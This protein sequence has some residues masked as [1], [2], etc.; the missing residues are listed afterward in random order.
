MGHE[1]VTVKHCR[2]SAKHH[3]V[4]KNRVTRTLSY[5]LSRLLLLLGEDSCREAPQSFLP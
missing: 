3:R 4:R 5:N 2:G 1:T